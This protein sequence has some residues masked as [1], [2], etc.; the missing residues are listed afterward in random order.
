MQVKRRTHPL[1]M[2]EPAPWFNCR[3]R[4]RERYAF[5][6]VAGRYIVLSFLGAARSS[7]ATEALLEGVW[8]IRER[9]DDEHLSFF[10]VSTEAAPPEQPL[11]KDA[12]PG[13]RFFWDLDRSV[14]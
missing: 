6:T 12:I 2:G 5:D 9:F 13:I 1:G 10:G 4:M 3:T 14:S 8:S 7:P 11:L